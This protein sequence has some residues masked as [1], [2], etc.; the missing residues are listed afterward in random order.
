MCLAQRN[1]SVCP[2]GVCPQKGDQAGD[3]HD[4]AACAV[5]THK[6]GDA[7]QQVLDVFASHRRMLSEHGW[8]F[9]GNLNTRISVSENYTP[10]AQLPRIFLL[11]IPRPF[12]VTSPKNSPGGNGVASRFRTKAVLTPYILWYIAVCCEI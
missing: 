8:R 3:D 7:C 12:S 10:E 9:P 5:T 1:I 4:Q 6:I 11:G 2:R